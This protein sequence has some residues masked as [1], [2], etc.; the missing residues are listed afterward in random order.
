MST[1]V[2][3]AA[4]QSTPPDNGKDIDEQLAAACEKLLGKR[5][6]SMEY[7]GGS[8]RDSVKI[9]SD[10]GEVA[11]ASTRSRTARADNERKV[12]LALAKEN[13]NAP[14]LLATNG[15][16]L[17]IQQ[18]I[19]GVWLTEA[20]HAASDLQ[21]E[22]RLDNALESLAAIQQ[23]GSRAG[24]DSEM[25]ALGSSSGWV[26]GLLERPQVIGTFFNI[27]AP[28]YDSNALQGML[29]ARSP[30]FVK[31][32]ARPGN[33]IARPDEQVFWIDWEHSGARNRL[34]DMVWLMADEWVPERPE[35]EGR[36]L[37]KHLDM[38]SDDLS[39][40]DAENYFY[41]M[42]VF[43]LCVRM[44]LIF[45]YKK[46]GKWWN[47]NRC[48]AGDKVGVTRRNLRRVCLRGERWAKKNSE[49]LALAR[50]FK[51]MRSLAE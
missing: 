13:T 15:K 37:K 5:I 3:P 19:P 27:D 50:W 21:I 39:R 43:H 24:L 32:D 29:Q 4:T 48:L 25:E 6:I 23:A 42:G 36:L 45:R 1:A 17:L 51:Q 49:T 26:A 41:A 20:L 33:A 2:N 22:L 44:G 46:D 35:I 12:L 16:R 30:R 28:D 7:P 10:D 11:F 34:D 38:F 31:W 9:V 40:Q 8:S 18:S 14:K 47:Y